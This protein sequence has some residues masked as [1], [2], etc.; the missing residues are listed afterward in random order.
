MAAPSGN[1]LWF[2][3]N[4]RRFG[5]GTSMFSSRV[6]GQIT[7]AGA[8]TAYPVTSPGTDLNAIT[9]GPDGNVWFTDLASQVG[10]VEIATATAPP[11]ADLSVAGLLVSPPLIPVHG[12]L[13]YRLA[14]ANAGPSS[15]SGVTV[16]LPLA[17]A[18][19]Y[20]GPTDAASGFTYVDNT[21]T[22]TR[23]S[24]LPL[25]G[26]L[27]LTLTIPIRAD[28]AGV[29]P[30]F[31]ASVKS[32]LADNNSGDNTVTLPTVNVTAAATASLAVYGKSTLTTVR[33]N[34][35]LIYVIRVTNSGQ[36]TL[37]DIGVGVPLPAN[38][39]FDGGSS[40]VR[41]VH[42]AR[43]NTDTVTFTQASL[44][45]PVGYFSFYFSVHA[46]A[47]GSVPALVASATSPTTGLG[48]FTIP[49]VVVS[50]AVVTAQ[51]ADLKLTIAGPT[52]PVA[53]GD[54]VTYTITIQ[55]VG[56]ATATGVR[57][58]KT[59][60]GLRLIS[61]VPANHSRLPDLAAHATT[62]VT[63]HARAGSASTA[64]N[65]VVTCN[66]PQVNVNV[67]NQATFTTHGVQHPDLT[68]SLELRNTKNNPTT[69]LRAGDVNYYLIYVKN[70]G[71][72][73]LNSDPNSST[74]GVQVTDLLPTGLDVISV[75]LNGVLIPSPKPGQPGN[76]QVVV[77]PGTLHTGDEAK[78]VI[79]VRAR[80]DLFANAL[81][82]N[83]TAA[84]TKTSFDNAVTATFRPS[85]QDANLSAADSSATGSIS[86]SD[87]GFGRGPDNFIYYIFT[88]ILKRNP[89]AAELFF[90]SGD[91][92]SLDVL[93]PKVNTQTPKDILHLVY[94]DANEGNLIQTFWNNFASERSKLP[95]GKNPVDLNA[96][97]D[98]AHLER[99]AN[100][101][102]DLKNIIEGYTHY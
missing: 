72:A 2:S 9:A 1:D 39:H 90:W 74:T 28:V 94:P 76:G 66:A 83:F 85:P 93:H 80:V 82:Q 73:T 69:F 46:T 45:V 6:I 38:V 13:T 84:A 57:F 4:Y 43:N 64:L 81:R 91:L 95:A 77:N 35:P 55:N 25:T 27:P 59:S 71:P 100:D 70:N 75:R 32:D 36:S 60:T 63:V 79:Q 78:I 58:R 34:D 23:P 40:G 11:S 50:P 15:A 22:Y 52:G 10:K 98:F 5:T 89:T 67:D 96:I 61:Y 53:V 20:V 19:V 101:K 14:V 12:T 51:G 97:G 26:T 68:V 30:S 8:V 41:L 3:S 42:D 44:P 92:V 18:F 56:N 7:P 102:T 31:R 33:V 29:T 21:V 24:D 54:Q 99:V 16:T 49:A 62:T 88:S 86:L 87:S 65:A 37:T 47:A 48:S 17:P